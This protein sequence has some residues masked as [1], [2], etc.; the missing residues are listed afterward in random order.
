MKLFE[1]F[2]FFLV[3]KPNCI[4]HTIP[5]FSRAVTLGLR[6]V[7][8]EAKGKGAETSDDS[9]REFYAAISEVLECTIAYSRNIAV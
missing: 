4:S 9:K 8:N 1:R 5:D 3:S 2:V 6:E 7:I